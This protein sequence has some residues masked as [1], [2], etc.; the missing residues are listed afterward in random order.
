MRW[1]H[2]QSDSPTAIFHANTADGGLGI[3]SI[4]IRVPR[5]RRTRLVKMTQSDDPLI[6]IMVSSRT[7]EAAVRLGSGFKRLGEVQITNK[8]SEWRAWREKLI[9]KTDGR[10][11]QYHDGFGDG[12]ITEPLFPAKGWEF[13]NALRV[14]CNAMKT[15]ARARRGDRG[16]PICRLDKQTAIATHISQMCQLTHGLS[17][18]KRHDGIVKLVRAGLQRVGEAVGP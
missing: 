12:W 8:Q 6:K 11:L 5:L 13:V 7:G 1:L 17:R 2:L 15:P 4:V 14:R 9:S 10:G 16:D 18:V 3:P